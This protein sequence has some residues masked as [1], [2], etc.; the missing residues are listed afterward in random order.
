MEYAQ[1]LWG[2]RRGMLELDILLERYA[3]NTYLEA[4]KEEQGRF[5]ALLRCQDQEL[6]DWMVKRIPAPSEFEP[7]IHRILN[8]VDSLRS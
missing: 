5:I 1:V 7:M 8:S 4:S 2:C 6:F 3:R